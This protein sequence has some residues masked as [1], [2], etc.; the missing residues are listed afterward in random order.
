MKRI[1]YLIIFLL[2]IFIF[3]ISANASSASLSV[4]SESVYVGDSFTVTVDVNSSAAWNVHT[5][6][7]GPVEGCIINQAD[8]SSDAMDTNKTFTAS[9]T[10]TSEG[11]ITISLTGDVTSVNDDNAVDVSGTKSVSVSI[12]PAP[13]PQPQP[14]P[15]PE[16]EKPVEIKKIKVNKFEIIG[17]PIDFKEDTFEY[18]IDVLDSVTELYII[19]EGENFDITGNDRVSIVDKNEVTVKLTNENEN[20]EYKI[21]LNKIKKNDNVDN[22]KCEETKTSKKD[23][24]LIYASGFLVLSICIFGIAIKF[25]SKKKIS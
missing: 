15:E 22:K 16:P 25:Y 21:K 11:T 24:S 18:T 5:T 2:S 7:S 9:C 8:A 3:N 14:E 1:N 23:Y 4:S 17:Y 6:A 10:A 12:R 19:I 13:V 20:K